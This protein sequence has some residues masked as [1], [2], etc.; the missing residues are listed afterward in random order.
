MEYRPLTVT[1]KQDANR[2]EEA[3]YTVEIP[4]KENPAAGQTS[5]VFHT[6]GAAM[7]FVSDYY[8]AEEAL[9]EPK[10]VINGR[11]YPGHVIKI[12]HRNSF[13]TVPVVRVPS[14]GKFRGMGVGWL[15][16]DSNE[17]NEG[18]LVYYSKRYWEE[19]TGPKENRKN[20]RYDGRRFPAS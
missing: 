1:R 2:L 8:K 15:H 19:A 16:Y 17:V 4:W 5:R 3:W 12:R 13:K 10:N 7:D 20:V 14:D 11:V 6:R 18:A 9:A